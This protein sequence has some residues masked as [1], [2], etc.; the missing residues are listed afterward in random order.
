MVLHANR[1]GLIDM[2]TYTNGTRVDPTP[3]TWA[4][5]Q[6]PLYPRYSTHA[7]GTSWIGSLA[8][9]STTPGAER[10]LR[11]LGFCGALAKPC[12]SAALLRAVVR[13]M[14]G[15]EDG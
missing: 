1:Q 6:S 12:T 15:E 4:G 9:N 8:S 10:H 5:L 13:C 11:T 7:R 2:A 3:Y 14:D